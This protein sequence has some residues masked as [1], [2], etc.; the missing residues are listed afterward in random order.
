[1]I[2]SRNPALLLAAS[3]TLGLA[4]FAPAAHAADEKGGPPKATYVPFSGLA[5]TVVR[6]DGGRGV[7][8]VDAGIDIPDAKLHVVADK[9]MPRLYDA[10]TQVLQGYAAALLPGHV[11]DVDYLG[12]QLQM[13]TDRVLGRPGARVLVGGVMV[14]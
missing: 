3:L 6:M 12:H 2:A 10:F 9:V 5:T 13:A 7:M 4:A 1:M 11:P 14:N 8:T